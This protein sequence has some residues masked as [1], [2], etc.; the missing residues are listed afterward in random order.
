M[1]SKSH[2][3][4][5]FLLL[6]AIVAS[7]LLPLIIFV[8]VCLHPRCEKE[9]FNLLE[10][11]V[12]NIS[13]A[14]K[15]A[16]V[17]SFTCW[18][19]RLSQW[20]NYLNL[21][22]ITS[23]DKATEFILYIVGSDWDESQKKDIKFTLYRKIPIEPGINHTN[24]FTVK[25]PWYSDYP[26]R[27]Y[28]TV[29]YVADLQGNYY[30]LE[31]ESIEVTSQSESTRNILVTVS[32][33]IVALLSLWAQLTVRLINEQ[34]YPSRKKAATLS[35]YWIYLAIAIA[36]GAL[37]LWLLQTSQFKFTPYFFPKYFV[38]LGFIF[39]PIVMICM[40]VLE[41]IITMF[42]K[43]WQ[44]KTAFDPLGRFESPWLYRWAFVGFN[45]CAVVL[46][47][48]MILLVASGFDEIWLGRLVEFGIIILAIYLKC[49]F[50]YSEPQN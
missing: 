41:S 22:I 35:L 28:K 11:N 13:F 29:I 10:C 36:M 31:R 23:T 47:I 8:L 46:L 37:I 50:S 30:K 44:N 3:C 12:P 27:W 43:G 45:I 9:E 17:E 6:V 25:I 24:S 21:Y 16:C 39:T 40:S 15:I 2:F 49:F 4:K 7:L 20:D 1:F 26:S 38:G 34:S 18:P 19:P 14:T 48:F 33:I 32:A 5:K 42:A